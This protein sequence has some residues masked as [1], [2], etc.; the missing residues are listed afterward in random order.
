MTSQDQPDDEADNTFAHIMVKAKEY[1]KDIA[2]LGLGDIHPA[3]TVKQA[4][5]DFKEECE[6]ERK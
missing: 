4:K 1:G 6:Y 5:I 3:Y 2:K